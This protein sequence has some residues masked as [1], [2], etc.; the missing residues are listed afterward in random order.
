MMAPGLSIYVAGMLAFIMKDVPGQIWEFVSKHS[1]TTLSMTANTDSFFAL[2]EW[3][4]NS[5]YAKKFRTIRVG[6]NDK[7]SVGFGRHFFIF[8]KRMC[9]LSR[10]RVQN[11]NYELE[12]ISLS[13]FGRDQ[14]ILRD[15]L[16]EAMEARLQS[17]KTRIYTHPHGEWTLHAEQERRALSTVLL[18]DE[19]RKAL[20]NHLN[21]YVNQKDWYL[22]HGIPYRTGICLS[23]PP[24]TGKTSLVRAICAEY[25]LKL[26]TLDLS[27]VGNGSLMVL[28]SRLE[29]KSLLLVEDIDTISVTEDRDRVQPRGEKLSL[30]TLTLGGVLNALDGVVGSDGRILVVTTNKLAK[31]DPALLRPGRIDLALELGYLTPPLFVEAMKNFFPNFIVTNID[32]PTT[33][34]PA[35]L[36]QIILGHKDNPNKVLEVIQRTK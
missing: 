27:Q 24:G 5:P 10:N 13:Y 22:K 14:Q 9:W 26:C 2:A 18:S 7:I 15:I 17:T 16:K 8:K 21:D 36:Q 28:M 31:L 23:G 1:T 12:E 11:K 29:P 32:W 30:E 25:K 33:M 19:N 6:D 34:T 20:L 35:T 3:I 4:E